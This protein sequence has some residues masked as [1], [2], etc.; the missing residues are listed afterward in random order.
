MDAERHAMLAAAFAYVF[1]VPRPKFDFAL[2]KYKRGATLHEAAGE[3]R[4]AIAR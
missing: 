3:L 2:R 1:E 4:A